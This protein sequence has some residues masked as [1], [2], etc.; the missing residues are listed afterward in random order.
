MVKWLS[1]SFI[2]FTELLN[3]SETTK[4]PDLRL[5]IP[6]TE[7]KLQL[8]FFTSIFFNFSDSYLNDLNI[9]LSTLFQL[10]KVSK[11]FFLSQGKMPCVR[12][13]T[14]SQYEKEAKLLQNLVTDRLLE[15]LLFLLVSTDS[16]CTLRTIVKNN[17]DM[18]KECESCVAIIHVEPVLYQKVMN[19]FHFNIIRDT[20]TIYNV[21][22]NIHI[23]KE[24][25]HYYS[26][27][28]DRNKQA[29]LEIS[30]TS[31]GEAEQKFQFQRN[32]F[33]MGEE[34]QI[35]KKCIHYSSIK[36]FCRFYFQSSVADE[37]KQLG[38]E[39]KTYDLQLIFS[40]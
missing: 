28:A 32:C 7:T 13:C 9:I 38:T 8:P 15:Y 19:Y 40:R 16:Y 37:S 31:T 14:D 12:V 5:K 26:D 20:L 39:C 25:I 24:D 4:P 35:S 3:C 6:H 11:T 30:F 27:K 22:F 29:V 18:K 2:P 21:T 17:H 23:S 36:V 34:W 33:A 1:T 10:M